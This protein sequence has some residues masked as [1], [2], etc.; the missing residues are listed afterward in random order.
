VAF[1]PGGATGGVVVGSTSFFVA[2]RIYGGGAEGISI[3]SA[4]V[5]NNTEW[6][7]AIPRVWNGSEWIGSVPRKWNGADWEAI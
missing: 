7:V 1:D 2:V 3:S 5:W 6:V 4:R